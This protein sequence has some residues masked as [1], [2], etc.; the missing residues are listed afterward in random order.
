MPNG[1]DY[2]RE[3]DGHEYPNEE[4]SSLRY[5]SHGC[6]CYVA[7][8]TSGG[9]IGLDPWGECPNNPK[10]GERLSGNADYDIVVT[11]RIRRGEEAINKLARVSEPKRQLEAKLAEAH[12]QLS[13]YAN[14]VHRIREGLE[15]EPGK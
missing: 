15:N 1:H 7:A 10:G 4:V 13:W 3:Y 6:K 14:F 9:P 2:L 5:C 11:R 12:R 8:F